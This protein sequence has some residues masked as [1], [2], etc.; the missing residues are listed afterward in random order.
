MVTKPISG[1]NTNSKRHIY[2]VCTF[3]VKLR[4]LKLKY[5]YVEIVTSTGGKRKI[6]VG[7]DDVTK[8]AYVNKKVYTQEAI[9]SVRKLLND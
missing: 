4:G 1:N 2:H 5:E 3:E 8:T 7:F 6:Q 9:E